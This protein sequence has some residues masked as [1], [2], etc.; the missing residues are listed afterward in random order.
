[1]KFMAT[2][3]IAMLLLSTGTARV[4]PPAAI[5]EP[6]V[7]CLKCLTTTATCSKCEDDCSNLPLFFFSCSSCVVDY[8]CSCFEACI[9]A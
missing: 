8:R 3:A 7:G 2:V 1:M 6:D 5:Q 9:H 4:A